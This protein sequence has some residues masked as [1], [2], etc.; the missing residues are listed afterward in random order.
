MSRSRSRRMFLAVLALAVLALAVLAGCKQFSFFSVLGDKLHETPLAISPTTVTVPLS[1]TVIFSA[2]GGQPPYSFTLASGSGTI[3][4]GT[5]LY[6]APTTT[7]AAS[8]R[9]T[10]AQAAHCDAAINISAGVGPLAISPTSVTMGPGGSLTFVASGGTAPYAFSLTASGSGSPSINGSTGA[11]TAGASTGTDTVQVQD[12]SSGTRS[13]TITVTAVQTNVDYTI[14]ATSFPSSGTGG[15]AIP[16]GYTFTIE[17]LGAAPGAQPVSWWVYISDDGTLGSGDS[18]LSGGS[19]AALPPGA[20]V[21]VP[22]AG[23]WPLASGAKRLFVMVASADDLTINN[24]TSNGVPVTL[25]LP[26]YS[27]AVAFSS[28]STT[29]GGAFTGTLTIDN[30]STAPGALDLTWSVYASLNNKT[31]DAGDKLVASGTIPGGLPGSSGSGDLSFNS[32][33]PSAAGFYYLLADIF[34]GDDGNAGNNFSFSASVDVKAP[35]VPNVDYLVQ[36]VTC[37]GGEANPGGT[38]NGSFEYV[39]QGD[40]GLQPV[41]WTAYASLNTTL[42][43]SDTWLA[44]GTASALGGG[45][46]SIPALTFSG[47]WPLDYGSYY[48]LV[49]IS[50]P[51]DSNATNNRAASAAATAIGMFTGTLAENNHE[52][53]GDYTNLV[54]VYDLGVTLQPGMSIYLEGNMNNADVDDV[55]G[56]KCGTA[57][58]IT[59][60]MSWTGQQSMALYI[61]QGPPTVGVKAVSITNAEALSISWAAT[62]GTQYWIDVTN[63]PPAKNLGPYV[64]IVTAN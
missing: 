1:G 26:D 53:N 17:N 25:A 57:T 56:V 12:A 45:E 51:E 64:L 7:G 38:V 52:P 50:N 32:T 11:Y 21:D 10:D 60:S 13:A 24:N 39:N 5:G 61:W 35:P 20:T 22:L 30:L 31:I 9:V 49:A 29:T 2:T 14:S 34:A 8:V 58:T 48:L 33:W 28:G 27:P 46:T 36:N 59:A 16:G 15:S 55:L 63:G 62:P 54:Q 18:L 40:T 4:S 6:T 37:T 23:S 3:N 44:S 47:L 42:D 19:T 41:S 43:G